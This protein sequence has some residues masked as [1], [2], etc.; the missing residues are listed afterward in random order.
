M[1]RAL[2][3]VERTGRAPASFPL[4][5][6]AFQYDK[7]V[8]LPSLDALR[9]RIALRTEIM[10]NRG[11]VAEAAALQER[12]PTQTTARQAIGYKE[13]NAFLA[14]DLTLEEAKAAVTLATTQYA[15]RQRTWFRKEKDATVHEALA[16]DRL[17]ALR[18]WL[19]GYSA[20]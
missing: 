16:T 6:P 9:P 10:F 13:A 5:Q 7:T 12:F 4:T 19:E 17:E 8:L 2:E 1:V 15:K 18:A 20:V 3:I 14:G 11:L